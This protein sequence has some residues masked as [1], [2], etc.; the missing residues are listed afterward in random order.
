MQLTEVKFEK[1]PASEVE[2][3]TDLLIHENS[4]MKTVY[5]GERLTWEGFL[6]DVESNV[7]DVQFYFPRKCVG[8]QRDQWSLR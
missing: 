5:P 7:I 1:K 4:Q 2:D 3:A 6:H 8:A